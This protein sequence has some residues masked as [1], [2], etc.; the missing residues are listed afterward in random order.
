M[1]KTALTVLL[2]IAGVVIIAF[3]GMMT[4]GGGM[5]GGMG[6]MMCPM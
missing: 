3:I 4:V 5:M 6:G 2:V 1:S